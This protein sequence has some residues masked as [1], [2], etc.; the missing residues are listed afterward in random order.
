MAQENSKGFSYVSLVYK[1]VKIYSAGFTFQGKVVQVLPDVV[2]LNGKEASTE[3][4]IKTVIR[5]DSISGI[6]ILT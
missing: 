4:I 1:L 6:D 5:K 3:G 2:I